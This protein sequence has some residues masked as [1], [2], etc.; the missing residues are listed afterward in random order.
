VLREIRRVV[1]A[2]QDRRPRLLPPPT[3][4]RGV[5]YLAATVSAPPHPTTRQPTRRPRSQ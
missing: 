3:T 4:S 2:V 1:A 5:T